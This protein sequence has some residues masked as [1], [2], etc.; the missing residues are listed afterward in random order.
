ML[1][2][3]RPRQG[4]ERPSLN[5]CCQV[6]CRLAM[7]SG[8]FGPALLLDATESSEELLEHLAALSLQEPSIQKL[9]PASDSE[10][11]CM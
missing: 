7:H 10:E 4:A 11:L 6:L 8:L 2:L 9:E 1:G 5:T 3:L